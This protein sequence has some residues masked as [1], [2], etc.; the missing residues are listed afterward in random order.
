MPLDNVADL[1]TCFA[2][3][4]SFMLAGRVV[5]IRA[6]G[7]ER[8]QDFAAFILPAYENPITFVATAAAAA[9]RNEAEVLSRSVMVASL[10][11]ADAAFVESLEPYDR[12]LLA[13]EVAEINEP[14]FQ[15]ALRL[16]TRVTDLL[17]RIGSGRTS[18]NTSP[19]TD[20]TTSAVSRPPL[21]SVSSAPPNG[22]T[23]DA[24][25]PA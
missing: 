22:P 24:A 18:S 2:A 15:L 13:V 23:V 17:V 21:P 20:T 3:R 9:P 5:E 12:S 25:P 11:N 16:Q 1:A 7:I 10:T 4:K 19:N 14:G 8:M 6:L